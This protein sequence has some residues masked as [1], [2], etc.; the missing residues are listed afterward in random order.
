MKK[1]LLQLLVCATSL[2]P[3]AHAQAAHP[4]S[5]T[6]GGF[7]PGATFKL[8]MTENP[9]ASVA[10]VTGSG[11]LKNIPA[12]YPK[13][14]K[15]TTVTFKIGSQGQLI[16]ANFSIPFHNGTATS[17]VYSAKSSSTVTN[18]SQAALNKSAGKVTFMNLVLR[19]TTGSGLSTKIT[20]I[21][22]LLE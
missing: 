5:K 22:Y 10:G 16:V 15:G 2:L 4:V 17:N 11:V 19:K 6:F 21:V 20:Q 1:L 14:K 12:G 8:T 9:I 13:Y 3:F 18:F 7:A